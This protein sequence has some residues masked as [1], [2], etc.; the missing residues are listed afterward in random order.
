[1]NTRLIRRAFYCLAIL[2]SS[3]PVWA[4]TYTATILNPPAFDYAAFVTGISG[5]HQAG[6]ASASANGN[7]NHALLW[8]SRQPA[9]STST[10][11]A[12]MIPSL[13]HLRDNTGGRRKC[14][15]LRL[16]CNVVERHSGKRRGSA[17][18]RLRFFRADA[19][20]LNPSRL[21]LRP[22][23]RRERLTLEGHRRERGRPTSGRFLQLLRH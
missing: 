2:T 9:M 23:D 19:L 21:W 4:V 11:L 20:W 12:S 14:L 13:W 5:S 17:S 16:A 8:K 18:G 7:H 15:R 3:C 10:R 1:M 6:F 22:G